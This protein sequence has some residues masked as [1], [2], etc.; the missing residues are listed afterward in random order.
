MKGLSLNLLHC[1]PKSTKNKL[2][3]TVV[4]IVFG[5]LMFGPKSM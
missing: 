1:Y 5:I 4:Q 2:M 3:A